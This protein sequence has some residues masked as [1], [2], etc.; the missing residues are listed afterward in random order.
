MKLVSPL[1]L[2][3]SHFTMTL[4]AVFTFVLVIFLNNHSNQLVRGNTVWWLNVLSLESDFPRSK[5]GSSIFRCVT[6]GKFLK[7]SEPHF[8]YIWNRNV[9]MVHKLVVKIEWVR[10]AV[11]GS[12][13]SLN[14]CYLSFLCLSRILNVEDRENISR[15]RRDV[16]QSHPR[17]LM[18]TSTPLMGPFKKGSHFF[19][20]S[21]NHCHNEGHW[22]QWQ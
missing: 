19:L 15:G 8:L 4:R 17:S 18:C 16:A 1:S 10:T 9:N 22:Y 12:D 2:C 3:L 7:L 20:Q 11:P 13:K 14:V 6:L 5:P 21:E